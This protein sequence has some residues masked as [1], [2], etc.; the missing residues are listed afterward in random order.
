HPLV[1]I[2]TLVYE[3][4][5]IHPFQD[6]NGRLSRIL[7]TLLLLREGYDFIQYASLEQEVERY[8]SDYYKSLML[9][10]RFRGKDR[11]TIES[12]LIFLL[13]SVRSVT[14]KLKG[15]DNRTLEEPSALYLNRR[16][17]SVL[18]YFERKEELSVGDIDRLLP[19]VSRNTLKY[20]LA[21]LKEAGYIRRHGKGRGTVY[22]ATKK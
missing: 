5:T 2:G 8:K 6:G 19:E 1:V 7:T 22:V 3:F 11:E 9:A 18:N 20:D 4:L 17:R 14:R 15:N 13:R 12:W 16:Q 21:R 10:Q